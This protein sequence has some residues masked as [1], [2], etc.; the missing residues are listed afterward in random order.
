MFWRMQGKADT[1][2]YKLLGNLLLLLCILTYSAEETVAL[3]LTLL[4]SSLAEAT[5]KPSTTILLCGSPQCIG[6]TAQ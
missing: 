3:R 1:V 6:I 4:I 2:R 5:Q